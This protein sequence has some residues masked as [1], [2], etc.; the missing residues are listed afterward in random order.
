MSGDKREDKDYMKKVQSIYKA[1]RYGGSLIGVLSVGGIVCAEIVRLMGEPLSLMASCYVAMLAVLSVLLFMWLFASDSE[2]QI[3]AKWIEADK[4]R[5]PDA[6]KDMLII[7]LQLA[8]VIGLF[9]AA[10]S[11]F[12]FGVMFVIYSLFTLLSVRYMNANHLPKAFEM[13]QKHYGKLLESKAESEPL[14]ALKRKGL[15]IV[16]YYFLGRPHTPR[17]IAILVS[18][19]IGLGLAIAWKVFDSPVVGAS[20]Y[21][22]FI[23]V[24]IVSEIVILHWRLVRDSELGKVKDKIYALD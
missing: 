6:I 20:A 23:G 19:I 24:I 10:R 13:N 9:F 18:S 16:E 5:V 21:I 14:V 1:R 12:W 17:H 2:L 11:P 8:V 15:D 3:L 22:L 4:Y 7:V